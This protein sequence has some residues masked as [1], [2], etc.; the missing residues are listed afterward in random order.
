MSNIYQTYD[1]SLNNYELP[2]DS[3][4]SFGQTDRDI[5]KE[6]AYVGSDVNG[7]P[8]N[9][10]DY[11]IKLTPSVSG[12]QLIVPSSP[13]DGI[14]NFSDA[15]LF[16]SESLGNMIDTV[17]NGRVGDISVRNNTL[18]SSG[19]DIVINKDNK[20]T[21]VKGVIEQTSLSDIFFSE[22]NM[23]VL[24]KAIRY[25]VFNYTDKVIHNQPENTLYIIMRSIMLQYANFN[26]STTNLIEEIQSLNQR[27]IDYS[28]ENI[29]SN[30]KQYMGYL[31]D[32]EKLPIPMDHP[33]YQNKNN[34][35]YDIS[36]LL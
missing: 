27:V 23:D 16:S 28:S 29:S 24:Q 12:P 33:S 11:D 31:N 8:Q 7:N 35:T 6:L 19:A 34:F 32:I 10:Y 4:G 26:I 1:S 21:S 17:N 22:M 14:P 25:K 15:S 20:E 3:V 36:N 30:V 18:L 13:D 9:F 5:D 2:S